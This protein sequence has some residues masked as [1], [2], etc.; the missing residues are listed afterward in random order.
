MTQADKEAQILLPLDCGVAGWE[1]HKKSCAVRW[2][3]VRWPPLN[4]KLI[5]L[6]GTKQPT[7]VPPTASTIHSLHYQFF[8]VKLFKYFL[9]L[10]YWCQ[11][12]LQLQENKN[13]HRSISTQQ[14]DLQTYRQWWWGVN[15]ELLQQSLIW[16]LA[17]HGWAGQEIKWHISF[18]T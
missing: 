7:A 4:L 16:Q 14:T 6:D 9:I 2:G 1:V 10:I 5:N 3:K 13:N 17:W 11:L 15:Q 8:G 12:H 18:P